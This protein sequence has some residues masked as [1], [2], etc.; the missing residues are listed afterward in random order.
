MS[1]AKH[2]QCGLLCQLFGN[3]HGLYVMQLLPLY[4][5]QCFTLKNI[6]LIVILTSMGLEA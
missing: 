6:F 3:L 5:L 2:I 1:T 4:I